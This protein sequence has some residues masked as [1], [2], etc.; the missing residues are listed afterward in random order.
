MIAKLVGKSSW[1][2]ETRDNTTI[3]L[4]NKNNKVNYV[5]LQWCQ[6][7]LIHIDWIYCIGKRKMWH[8]RIQ[9]SEGILFAC[10]ILFRGS[11]NTTHSSY[12]LKLIINI[13]HFVHLPISKRGVLKQ[14]NALKKVCKFQLANSLA[15]KAIFGVNI[16]SG[17]PKLLNL[18][19]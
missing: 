17:V 11:A 6:R 13:I 10:S 8:A 12:S 9:T 7:Q 15:S 14:K 19:N 2:K 5:N 18:Y 4:Y 16:F 3:N 1:V